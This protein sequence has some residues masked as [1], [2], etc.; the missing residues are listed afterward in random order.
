MDT[1]IFS[2]INWLAVLAGSIAYFILGA[3][4]YTVLFGKAWV[5]YSGMDVN[6]P[7]MKKGTTQIMLS[8]LVLMIVCSIG[9]ALFIHKIGTYHWMTGA[10][11]GLIAGICFSVTG[12]SISYLYER[13]PL[14]L[15]LV[16]GVYCTV[17]CIIAGIIIS[18][19]PK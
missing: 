18:V 2:H 4:W 9:L 10:K 3:I 7:D 16:N 19:W 12:L 14:G 1:T 11:V 15:H 13:K 8:S 17:G 5:K 6:N